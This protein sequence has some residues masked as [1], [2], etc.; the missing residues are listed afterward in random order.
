MTPNSEMRGGLAR[1]A[2]FGGLAIVAAAALAVGGAA[3]AWAG[4]AQTYTEHVRGSDQLDP[5]FGPNPC[6]GDALTGTQQENVVDHETVKDA[7]IRGIFTEEAWVAT[8]DTGTGVTY[9]GHFTVAGNYILNQPDQINTFTFSGNLTGSDG[10]VITG[11][12]VTHFVLGADG[13]V[14]ISFDKVRLSCEIAG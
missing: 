1:R 7:D 13:R 14:Q 10:S 5:D 2:R 11:H 8:T 3:P 12:E 6:T 4:G 9:S